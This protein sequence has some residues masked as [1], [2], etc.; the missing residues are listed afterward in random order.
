MLSAVNRVY[1]LSL[2][3]SYVMLVEYKNVLML[4]HF[5]FLDKN[6]EWVTD[7]SWYEDY[8]ENF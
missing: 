5:L 1:L 4:V 7:D 2:M 8:L 3:N 6:P